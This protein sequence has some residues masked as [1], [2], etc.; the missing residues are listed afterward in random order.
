LYKEAFDKYKQAI[1]IKPDK[2]EAYN[3]WGTALGNLA[4]T[5]EGKE[6]ED[7]YKEAFDK[8]QQAIEYG[9]SSYNL[10]CILALQGDL[11]NAL[12]YLELSLSKSEV[13]VNFVE[14]DED[15]MGYL[16]Q[17]KLVTLLNKYK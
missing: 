17:R 12:K 16:N 14:N 11:E 8:F 7:L 15:W 10:S 1:K 13:D 4:K 2:H 9:A 6:E 5:K 3:N